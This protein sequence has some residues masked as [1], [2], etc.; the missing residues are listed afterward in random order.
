MH[1]IVF[2]LILLCAQTRCINVERKLT[3]LCGENGIC[4]KSKPTCGVQID[5]YGCPKC[6]NFNNSLRLNL[7]QNGR[8][9][10]RVSRIK[11]IKILNGFR[12]WENFEYETDLELKWVPE[13]SGRMLYINTSSKLIIVKYFGV[14]ISYAV[15]SST[16][17][18]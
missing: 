12:G 16:T 14:D 1:K 7:R 6:I 18:I 8:R 11:L 13:L 9:S 4:T 5:G 15:N 17:T 3:D 2:K 10:Y